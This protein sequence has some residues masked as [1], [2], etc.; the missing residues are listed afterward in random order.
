MIFSERRL[1]EAELDGSH[2]TH[3]LEVRESNIPA[4]SFY[5]SLGFIAAGRREYYYHDSHE[6][7]IVMRI[8]S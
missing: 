2:R 6:A 3:F 1:L 7:A 4:I 8:F 5:K